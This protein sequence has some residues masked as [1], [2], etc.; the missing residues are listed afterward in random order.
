MLDAFSSVVVAASAT[1]I[2]VAF[3]VVKQMLR[4]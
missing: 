4:R 1:M 2:C 3:I